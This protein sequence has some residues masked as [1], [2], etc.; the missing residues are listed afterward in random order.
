MKTAV[1]LFFVVGIMSVT[2]TGWAA[3]MD[4]PMSGQEL[5]QYTLDDLRATIDKATGENE[6]LRERNRGLREQVDQLKS[7]HDT[8]AAQKKVLTE[9]AAAFRA[10]AESSDR[11]L[12][13]LQE[14][15]RQLSQMEIVRREEVSSL[16]TDVVA[17]KEVMRDVQL[18]SPGLQKE[19]SEMSQY[20]KEDLPARLKK[21]A[22]EKKAV[23]Q[24]ALKEK[25][26]VTQKMVPVIARL[27]KGTV[28]ARQEEKKLVERKKTGEQKQDVLRARLDTLRE[29]EFRLRKEIAALSRG[30]TVEDVAQMKKDTA[31]LR[32]EGQAIN[33]AL[34]QTDKDVRLLINLSGRQEQAMHS[35]KVY[36]EEERELLIQQVALLEERKGLPSRVVRPVARP[37]IIKSSGDDEVRKRL[38][39]QIDRE[40]KTQEV[41][42][43]ECA[44][45]SR[46]IQTMNIRADR[47]RRGPS[48]MDPQQLAGEK[49]KISRL[50]ARF[51]AAE[52]TETEASP[53]K[54]SGMIFSEPGDFEGDARVAMAAAID[55]LKLREAVL[56]SSLAMIEE[57]F[58]EQKGMVETF[59]KEEPQLRSYLETLTSENKGLKEKIA[60]LTRAIKKVL[61]DKTP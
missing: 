44:S 58:Q 9:Q 35:M 1:V 4:R 28:A 57:R 55:D 39:I 56:S 10:K 50:L 16:R 49:E 30:L 20:L 27:N 54:E 33:K 7:L 21:Q 60:S 37:R 32:E 19:I 59:S 17:A 13:A 6:K 51:D 61:S 5:L 23:L 2:G 3:G 45:L 43:R 18:K 24:K 8:L 48:E 12:V 41:L 52:A 38:A 34:V 26:R 40:R 36:L 31:Q 14:K 11:E 22:Q 53:A 29:D 25:D 46:D 47:L 15:L 42:E